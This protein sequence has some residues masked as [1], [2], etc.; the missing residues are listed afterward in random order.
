MQSSYSRSLLESSLVLTELSILAWKTSPSQW[1]RVDTTLVIPSTVTMVS[2]PDTRSLLRQA[3][4][5]TRLRSPPMM[6]EGD[7]TNIRVILDN[8]E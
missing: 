5:V 4:A 2:E 3:S 6:G 7:M 1:E 8:L